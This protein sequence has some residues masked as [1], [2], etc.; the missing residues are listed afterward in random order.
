M[1][2]GAVIEIISAILTVIGIICLA[3]YISDV[4]FLPVEIVSAIRI[5]DEKA[6]ENADILLHTAERRTWSH[7]GKVT[8]VL[9][10]LKYAEDAELLELIDKSGFECFII[11]E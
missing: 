7:V 11:D 6:R 5:F 9:I 3:K 8:C 10:S 2:F 1:D 4:F